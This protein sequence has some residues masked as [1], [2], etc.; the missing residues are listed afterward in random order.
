MKSA[1]QYKLNLGEMD[2][3]YTAHFAELVEKYGGKSIAVVEGKI[4]AVANTEKEADQIARKKMPDAFPLVLTI[5]TE[6][7]LLCLL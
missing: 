5:P 3:W 6:E 4:V 2:K 1:Q 7:E